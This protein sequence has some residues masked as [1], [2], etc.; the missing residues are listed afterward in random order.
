M[1]AQPPLSMGWFIPTIGDTTSFSD[2]TVAIAPSLEHFERVALAAEAAGFEYVLIPVNSN[3]WDAWVTASFLVAKTKKLKALVAVKPG[4][5]HPVAQAKMVTTFDQMSGG[6][7]FLN[8]IAGL[9]ERDA[10]AEG[11]IASKEARYEQLAEEVT[12]LKRLWTEENV[13]FNG[14][15]Y[16]VHGP[17]IMPKPFQK[18]ASAVLPGWRFGTGGRDLG[19]TFRDASLLGRLSRA[20]RRRNQIAAYTR[21]EVRTWRQDPLWHAPAGHLPRE[22]RRSLG[23]RGPIDRRCR[24]SLEDS[25]SKAWRKDR[26]PTSGC[27]SCRR[28]SDENSGRICGL[29]LPKCAPGRALRWSAIRN[30]SPHQLQEFIDVGCSGFCLSGYPHH[31]EAERFGRMVMP[32]LHQRN[33]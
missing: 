32:L 9:S 2:P 15:Y 16:Q 11:Q 23:V 14:K 24:R 3:C 20:H 17:Q 6:R 28:L 30:R 12:L 26:L 21:G 5:I 13:E 22:R 4:F 18:P 25:S 33:L 8:L 1:T 19:G 29:A 31:E 27:R 10:I 7:L